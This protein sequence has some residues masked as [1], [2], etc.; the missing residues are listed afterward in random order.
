MRLYVRRACRHRLGLLC[1][2]TFLQIVAAYPWLFMTGGWLRKE[3]LLSEI[4]ACGCQ[5]GKTREDD[6]EDAEDEGGGGDDEEND[7]DDDDEVVVVP[8]LGYRSSFVLYSRGAD[9]CSSHTSILRAIANIIAGP[10][11]SVVSNGC[12]PSSSLPEVRGS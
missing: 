4:P 12:S 5:R 7:D 3:G 8:E 2:R 10:P 11:P 6:E 9:S 1:F